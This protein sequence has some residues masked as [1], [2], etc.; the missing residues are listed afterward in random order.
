MCIRGH[1]EFFEEWCWDSFLYSRPVRLTCGLN[2]ASKYAGTQN[3]IMYLR[4]NELRAVDHDDNMATA[5]STREH[6]GSRNV[7]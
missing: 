3:K 5:P 2:D 6:Q 4:T 1:I 7:G